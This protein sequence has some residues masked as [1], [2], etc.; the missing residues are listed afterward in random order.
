MAGELKR[1]PLELADRIPLP[2]EKETAAK[3]VAAMEGFD[4]KIVVLDDDPTG[5]Q[6]VHGVYVFTDW[7]V[8]TLVQGMESEQAMFFVL[9][10][11]RGFTAPQTETAHR[12][13]AYN[14][15]EAS[16]RTGKDFVLVSRSDSTLR[17]HYPLETEILRSALEEKLGIR[18]DGEV[19]MPYFKEGGRLTIGD[20]HYVKMGGELVPAGLTEFARDTTF[21]YRASDLKQWCEERTGGAF[22]AERVVSVSLEE[23]R[24]RDYE[25]IRTKLLGVTG[26]GKVVVNAAD[27]VD[28]EVFVTVLLDVI[29][30]GKQFLFRSAAGLV[31]VLGGVSRRPLLTREELCPDDSGLG[32]LVVVGSHVKK[33]TQQLECLLSGIKGLEEICFQAQSAL[34]PGGLEEERKRVLAEAER[35]IQAGK[36]AVVY[37]SRQVLRAS[38]DSSDQNLSLSVRISQALTGVVS[39]LTIRPAFVV[40]KGGITSSD[41][42]I[43]ALRVRKALVM[44][45]AAPGIPVWKTGEESKFPG[46]AYVIF[47]GNVGEVETLRDVVKTLMTKE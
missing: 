27:D 34:R 25:G 33:T 9:T 21:A 12:E 35:A 23:L 37:T 30:A 7:E 31:R 5:V 10:N 28:V 3:R 45:Q 16:R 13:I 22:P 32:G 14:L 15:A 36:T 38:Q 29:R 26:F 2:D 19:I 39:D 46:M 18:Y 1:M 47:P 11:S 41:V 4:R 44:G 42:G 43:K 24:R 17:G 6:T 40:A 8:D 20:V